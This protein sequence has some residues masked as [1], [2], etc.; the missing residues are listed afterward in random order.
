MALRDQPYIPLYIQD[1]MTDE[2]LNECCAATHGIYIKGIMCLMHKSETYG[3]I[4]LR[5]K[6]KQTD[7]QIKNFALKFDKHLPYTVD[8]IEAALTELLEEGVLNIDESTGAL[9]QKR[10]VKDNEISQKRVVSGKKGADKTRENFAKAKHEANSENE[11][12]NE[13]ATANDKLS[14]KERAEIFNAKVDE[15]SEFSESLRKNFKD[16]WTE[17]N[18]GGH[19]MRFEMEKVFD[20]KKRLNTFL[21]NENKFGSK[22][23]NNNESAG[24]VKERV[25]QN[26]NQKERNKTMFKDEP[27][28]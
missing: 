15:F 12:E 3:M 8:E 13:S 17:H 2:K 19:K 4:L 25:Q 21:R 22:K 7:S 28:G 26:L 6:D 10:M 20:L 11:Y 9:F 23:N 14:I 5:E 16:Y 1:I 18:E 27:I 24:H